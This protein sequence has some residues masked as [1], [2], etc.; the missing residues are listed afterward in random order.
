MLHEGLEA[1]KVFRFGRSCPKRTILCLNWGAQ[2]SIYM[3]TKYKTST[4]EAVSSCGRIG[5][6]R[7]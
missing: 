4:N 1:D 3:G 2:C 5:T 7:V 6:G